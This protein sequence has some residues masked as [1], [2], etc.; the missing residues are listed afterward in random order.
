MQVLRSS[1]CDDVYVKIALCSNAYDIWNSLDSIYGSNNCDL[2]DVCLDIKENATY[3]Q[4]ENELN[5]ENAYEESSQSCSIN[6]NAYLMAVEEDEAQSRRETS[7][8]CLTSSSTSEQSNEEDFNEVTSNFY[9]F[10]CDDDDYDLSYGDLLKGYM[11][12]HNDL[13][14]AKKQNKVFKNEIDNFGKKIKVLQNEI[15]S[16][17]LSKN[18][19][20]KD[21]DEFKKK[22]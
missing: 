17:T 4:E 22:S 13:E 2:V 12:T 21:K 19:L 8:E 6:N 5:D 9:S 10:N 18:D 16:L 3:L 14:K 7:M 11:A 20:Q 1:L 15:F